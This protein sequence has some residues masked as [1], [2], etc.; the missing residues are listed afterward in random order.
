MPPWDRVIV[1]PHSVLRSCI[2]GAVRPQVEE[3]IP[4][5]QHV[6]ADEPPFLEAEVAAEQVAAVVTRAVAQ[7]A[8]KKKK[9]PRKKLLKVSAVP[10]GA[11]PSDNSQPMIKFPGFVNGGTGKLWC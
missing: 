8:A 11:C 1:A 7:P 9:A 6:S 3:V 4:L 10:S 5:L 2:F